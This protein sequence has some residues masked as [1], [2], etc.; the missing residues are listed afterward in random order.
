MALNGNSFRRSP[1]MLGALMGSTA[2][3][4]IVLIILYLRL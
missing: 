1:L 4:S 2:I 3:L